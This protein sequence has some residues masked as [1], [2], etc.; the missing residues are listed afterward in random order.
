MKTFLPVIYLVVAV[1]GVNY[2][3]KIQHVLGLHV[4]LG[5]LNLRGAPPPATHFSSSKSTK[6][7]ITVL[8]WQN[9]VEVHSTLVSFF[10]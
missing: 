7:T 8:E 5:A 3:G 2:L 4:I 1:E 6:I 10:S 9:Y